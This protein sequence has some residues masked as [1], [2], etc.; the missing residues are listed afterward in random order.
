MGGQDLGQHRLVFRHQ[1][2]VNRAGGQ[3]GEGI[4]HGGKDGEGAGGLQGFHQTGG[5]HGG[6]EGGVILG[7]DGVFDDVLVGE[8]GCAAHHRVVL[9]HGGQGKKGGQGKGA[10]GGGEHRILRVGAEPF[11]L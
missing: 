11:R 10:N 9:R 4:V 7:V 2:R 3:G 1:Q 5:L 8:H 6:D